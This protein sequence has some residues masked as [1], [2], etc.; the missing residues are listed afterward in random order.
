MAYIIKYKGPWVSLDGYAY[1][2]LLYKDTAVTGDKEI[3]IQD[4][5]F[6]YT[7]NDRIISSSVDITFTHALTFAEFNDLLT[8]ES[9]VWR[10]D[11]TAKDSPA[12]IFFQGFLVN[13]VNEREM[14]KATSSIRITAT[15]GLQKLDN[16]EITDV[17]FN[18]YYPM[19][20]LLIDGLAKLESQYM[21]ANARFFYNTHD[22]A[23]TDIFLEQSYLIGDF[24]YKNDIET[25]SYG[26]IFNAIL[27]T[28]D[29]YL[30]K[31]KN[32][33]Y[34]ERYYDV[35]TGDDWVSISPA[36]WV[37]AT[38]T[39]KQ[40]YNKQDDFD[41]TRLSQI[42]T[43]QSGLSDLTIDIA[44][45]EFYSRLPN[46]W[47]TPL[48]DIVPSDT[49][50]GFA[51]DAE[52][53]SSGRWYFCQNVTTAN[54]DSSGKN[55]YGMNYY[56]KYTFDTSKTSVCK[57]D[58]TFNIRATKL[59]INFKCNIAT[60]HSYSE[61]TEWLT[62]IWIRKS[63]KGVYPDYFYR[64]TDNDPYATSGYMSSTGFIPWTLIGTKAA[65]STLVEFSKSFDLNE[66]RPYF[67]NDDRLLI[68]FYPGY[69]VNHDVPGDRGTVFYPITA[70]IGDFEIKIVPDQPDNQFIY[71]INSGFEN[72]DDIPL[73]IYDLSN[74]NFRDGVYLSD[75]SKTDADVGW[76]EE[77]VVV[78]D[79]LINEY[80]KS[81]VGYSYKTRMGLEA[82]IKFKTSVFMKPLSLLTDDNITDTVFIIEEYTFDMVNGIYTITAPEYSLDKGEIT[83]LY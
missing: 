52:I 5:Q 54:N 41:Y 62:V 2:V 55:S 65:G 82:N 7:K 70:I 68:F 81:R 78:Y 13:D 10:V 63:N 39:K 4:V 71:A 12:T 9:D 34:F 19:D 17:S 51:I 30:Y 79:S 28:F 53:A 23:A 50:N 80:A 77:D 83:L 1:E 56:L 16:I 38:A 48:S 59:I 76:K 11:I 44:P 31:Y 74:I 49:V 15:D 3:R 57:F 21:M 43:Y 61:N 27:E 42:L 37:A 32:S 18:E 66:V 14:T 36:Y 64:P 26:E 35:S 22:K 73:D 25:K 8:S 33:W 24:L 29:A 67:N 60:R 46:S 40:L 72:Q 6:R 45:S 75:G 58:F 47:N 69:Q 20:H